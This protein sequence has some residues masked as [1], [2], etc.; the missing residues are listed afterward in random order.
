MT[1]SRGFATMTDG[2]RIAWYLDGPEGAPLVMLSNSL[3]TTAA[4]WDAQ[5]PILAAR[6][7]VLR[8]DTRGHGA[9]TVTPGDYSLDRLGRDVIGVLDVLGVGRVPFCGLSLG[10]MTGQ[11][12]GVYAP[13]RIERLLLANTSAYMGPPEAWQQRIALVRSQ[14]MAAIADAVIS[15]WFTPSFVAAGSPACAAV[16]AAM[17]GTDPHGY[18]GCCAAI[19]DMDLRPVARLIACPTLV[20][21]GALDPATPPEHAQWLENAIA[22]ATL[23]TLTASHL[24]NVEQPAA[25]T[26]ALVGWLA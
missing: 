26:Q 5:M 11:W 19:R 21:S 22:G 14:G 9:S 23:V 2:A 15:R 13:D 7:R 16:R 6:H 10:G 8:Y 18:T 24:S 4:M 20:I 12:L 25:F 1:G 17:L 3:G